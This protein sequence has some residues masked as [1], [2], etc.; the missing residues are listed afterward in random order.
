M[1][2]GA[3]HYLLQL[4]VMLL[5]KGPMFKLPRAFPYFVSEMRKVHASTAV[6]LEIEQLAT[7]R[8]CAEA[9]LLPFSAD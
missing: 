6:L 9:S 7:E 1:L 5:R 2:K 4:F 3:A 8:G